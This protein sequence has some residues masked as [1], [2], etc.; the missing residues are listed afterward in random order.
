MSEDGKKVLSAIV[1]NTKKMGRLIDDLL[2]FSHL[3]RQELTKAPIDMNSLINEVIDELSLTKIK[4]QKAEFQI[5]PLAAAKGDVN[6]IK[7]V[8]TN[9][10]SNAIKYSSK[11]EKSVIQITSSNENGNIIYSVKDNGVGFDMKY[12]HKLFG[13]FERL[14][15]STEFDGQVLV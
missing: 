7:Q 13:V 4:D 10:I 12:Y 2:A 8:W 15:K 1:A 5:Q 11:K 14:H 3:N 6:M 9:L